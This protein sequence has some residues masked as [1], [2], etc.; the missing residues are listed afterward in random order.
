MTTNE[1]R[2]LLADLVNEVDYDT[3]K[4]L[5]VRQ[6]REEPE[7]AEATIKRM[8]DRLKRSGIEIVDTGEQP[9]L[10]D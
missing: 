8:I 10:L 9:L 7:L 6:C 3:H 5:F 1:A 2:Q 4:S